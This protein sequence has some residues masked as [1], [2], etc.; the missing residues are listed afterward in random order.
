M[1]IIKLAFFAVLVT[2]SPMQL[3]AEITLSQRME[4]IQEI[5]NPEARALMLIEI[6]LEFKANCPSKIGTLYLNVPHPTDH[7]IRAG[8]APE[9]IRDDVKRQEYIKAIE[10][11]RENHKKAQEKKKIEEQILEILDQAHEV[12]FTEVSEERRQLLL[13]IIKNLRLVIENDTGS[14]E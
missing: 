11:N 7:G 2:I 14:Q 10:E 13:N 3:P 6:A 4:A 12:V 9:T 8:V 5:K 1:S